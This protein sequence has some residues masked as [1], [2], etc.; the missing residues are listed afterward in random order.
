[1]RWLWPSAP[2]L[3]PASSLPLLWIYLLAVL[4]VSWCSFILQMSLRKARLFCPRDFQLNNMRCFSITSNIN[5]LDKQNIIY[6]YKWQ[7]TYMTV[8]IRAD[9]PSVHSNLSHLAV[10]S[11]NNSLSG[12]GWKEEGIPPGWSNQREHCSKA[13]ATPGSLESWPSAIAQCATVPQGCSLGAPE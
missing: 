12:Q 5:P 9:V 2:S 13:T 10:R 8:L 6:A 3:L 1:M 4:M 11:C 7:V